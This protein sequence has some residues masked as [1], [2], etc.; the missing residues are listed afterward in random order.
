[1][2]VDDARQGLPAQSPQGLC[3]ADAVAVVAKDNDAA[4]LG[5]W[6]GDEAAALVIASAT[7]L[8]GNLRPLWI[9]SARDNVFWCSVVER[10]LRPGDVIHATSWRGMLCLRVGPIQRDDAGAR[11]TFLM[12]SD[13]KRQR[14]L[15]RSG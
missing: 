7:P 11:Q 4:I 8:H 14:H 10:H 1:M 5:Y 13:P 15:Y 3:Q 6:V 2:R 9:G 12:V